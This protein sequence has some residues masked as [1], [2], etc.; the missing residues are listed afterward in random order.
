MEKPFQLLERLFIFTTMG[1]QI[2]V[3]LKGE[4]K[5]FG[6]SSQATN[7]RGNIVFGTVPSSRA[8]YRIWTVAIF[9]SSESAIPSNNPISR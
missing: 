5:I 1:Q 9:L 6:R 7:V 8:V 2:K 4:S 3:K